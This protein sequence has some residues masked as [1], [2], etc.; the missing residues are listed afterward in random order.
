MI[1]LVLHLVTFLA[2][3]T[4]G[5][6]I[7]PGPKYKCPE[8]AQIWP[9][10]CLAT[11]DEGIT[12]KCE[13]VS[14]A[15]LAA[16]M[17]FPRVKQIPIV[18]LEIIELNTEKLYGKLFNGVNITRL[19]I[20]NSP[21]KTI[22]PDIFFNAR[23][24]LEQLE[25][26]GTQ[27][28][29]YPNEALD[30]LQNLHTLIL[31]KH[32]ISNLNEHIKGLGSLKALQI[33]NG[34]ISSFTK[35]TFSGLGKLSRL[36]LHGNNLASVPKDSFNNFKNLE[37]LDLAWNQFDKLDPAYFFHL[38]KLTWFNG[39]HNLIPEFKRGAFARNGFLRVIYLTHN[40]ITKLDAAAF[41]GMRLLTRLYLSDNQI[42]DVGRGAFNSLSRIKTI[43]LARN[44]IKLVDYQMFMKLP[45][46]EELLIQENELS[47]IKTGAFQELAYVVVNVSH[48][49]ISAIEKDSFQNCV[50]M[51]ILD[52]SHNLIDNFT[53]GAFDEISYPNEWRL[54]YNKLKLTSDIP[55]KFM[56]GIK[57]LNVSHNELR[58]VNKNT[59][60]KLYEMHTVDLSYNNIS[61]I[62]SAIFTNLF[63]LRHLNM[64]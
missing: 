44:K 58:E 8:R 43:D 28:E 47:K 1:I 2:I 50:N 22:L 42:S 10:L 40:K 60:P 27:M 14:M 49:M 51:T 37:F 53:K 15:T 63:S 13:Q 12:M 4:R 25:L 54:Q 61:K 48:N 21:V 17:A 35:E 24:S 36:D 19:R 7:P 18:F 34:N 45:F 62:H 39:S 9:C 46:A 20:E 31:D 23:Q 56:A 55:L 41:R 16:A 59:F 30:E 11:S 38:N 33:S 32:N 26:V 29:T 57:M 52:M 64:R 5:E 6:Y 3:T